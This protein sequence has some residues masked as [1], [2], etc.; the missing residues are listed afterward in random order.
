MKSAGWCATRA[1][2]PLARIIPFSLDY[3][4]SI[5]PSLFRAFAPQQ[6][7]H[8]FRWLREH[9]EHEFA[10]SLCG[11]PP[12]GLVV[13]GRSRSL[14]DETRAALA[15]MNTNS[16]IQI[17]TYDELLDRFGEHI[18]QRV[19]DTRT[20][21]PR[22]SSTRGTAAFHRLGEKLRLLNARSDVYF[23]DRRQG[24]ACG[25]LNPRA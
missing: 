11:L 4:L 13:I 9:P 21:C 6:V 22:I 25:I 3:C 16:T 5:P 1:I 18:L 15:H 17:L 14:D 7:E 24:A 23:R 8:W 20:W 2:A 12:K 10:R 19:D